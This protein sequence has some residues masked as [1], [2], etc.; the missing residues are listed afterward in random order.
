MSTNYLLLK[1]KALEL[2]LFEHSCKLDLGVYIGEH[3]SVDLASNLTPQ[4]VKQ[5][6]IRMI[7]NA[8]YFT[9]DPDEFLREAMYSLKHGYSHVGPLILE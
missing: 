4:Q 2:H 3:A 6:A 8:S 1:S 7:E 9:S 5:L